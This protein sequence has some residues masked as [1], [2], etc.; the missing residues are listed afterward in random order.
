MKDDANELLTIESFGEMFIRQRLQDGLFSNEG[1]IKVC[2]TIDGKEER[3]LSADDLAREVGYT[4]LPFLSSHPDVGFD[5]FRKSLH[6]M[7]RHG[8]V[9]SHVRELIGKSPSGQIWDAI[10]SA[11]VQLGNERPNVLMI[12]L[13]FGTGQGLKMLQY[14][15][16][17][18]RLWNRLCTGN[19]DIFMIQKDLYRGIESEKGNVYVWVA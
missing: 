6:S 3:Y 10:E 9:I 4:M 14:K 12:Y 7:V 18:L 15:R 2:Y 5:S 8:K 19:A 16:L 13:E 1:D 11:C 17:K